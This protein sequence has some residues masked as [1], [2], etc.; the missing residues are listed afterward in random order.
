MVCV[1]VT[2]ARTSSTSA[3]VLAAGGEL[4]GHPVQPRDGVGIRLLDPLVGVVVVDRGR[5]ED[6]RAVAVVEDG[7]IAGEHH[8]QLGQLEVVHPSA[9]TFSQ[10]RTAS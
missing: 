3:T 1:L 5:H 10:W 6:D 2:S 7:D 4:A 8:R 9:G